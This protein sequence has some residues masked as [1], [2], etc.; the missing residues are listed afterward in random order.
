MV[1]RD[2]AALTLLSGLIDSFIQAYWMVARTLLDLR[3]F[4]LWEKELASRSLERAR[5]AFLEGEIGRPE[6]ANRTL[7]E[8]ALGWMRHHG[9]IEVRQGGR[10]KT[11]HL[12]DGRGADRLQTLID[13]I[14]RYI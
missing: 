11:L 14:G 1:L 2:P 6:A 10:R 7:V 12:A 8:S 4:P 3:A 9:V 13:S 5:R